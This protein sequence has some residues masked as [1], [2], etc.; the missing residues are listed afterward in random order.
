MIV[1]VPVVRV[2]P[3]LEQIL[4]AGLDH[5]ALDVQRHLHHPLAV[6]S[7][8]LAPDSTRPC[9]SV[10]G[11]PAAD[12]LVLLSLRDTVGDAFVDGY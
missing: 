4:V 9:G 12:L 5:P 7:R 11:S 2:V 8:T 6:A 1:P 10:A 3:R